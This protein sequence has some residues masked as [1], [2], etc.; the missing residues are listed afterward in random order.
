MLG[1]SS[2]KGHCMHVCMLSISF[3]SPRSLSSYPGSWAAPRHFSAGEEPRYEATRW[4]LSPCTPTWCMFLQGHH[5]TKT[6]TVRVLTCQCT[7]L[8]SYCWTSPA[9]F[10]LISPPPSAPP[11]TSHEYVCDKTRA[12]PLMRRTTWLEPVSF[13]T[14][15]QYIIGSPTEGLGMRLEWYSLYTKPWYQASALVLTH[16]YLILASAALSHSAL[17]DPV[18]SSSL[19][20]TISIS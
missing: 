3:H 11:H 1:T 4:L 13:Q 7:H 20:I 2:L 16:Y 17:A 19:P 8:P 18:S 9:C 14:L 10:S 6:H 5:M 12:E 15:P